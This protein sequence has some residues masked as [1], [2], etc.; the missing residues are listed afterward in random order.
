MSPTR[1]ITEKKIDELWQHMEWKIIKY[2]HHAPISANH[3]SAALMMSGSGAGVEKV[4]LFT[5]FINCGICGP[6][7]DV[8]G[9]AYRY[10]ASC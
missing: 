2:A 1:H 6:G 9:D 5:I 4:L 10:H 7:Y 8:D 3:F